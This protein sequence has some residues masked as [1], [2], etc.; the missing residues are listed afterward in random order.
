[1]SD[2]SVSTIRQASLDVRD[3]L[4]IEKI[5]DF[6]RRESGDDKFDVVEAKSPDATGVSSGGLFLT[7]RDGSGETQRLFLKY[8]TQAKV[9]P[10][11][12]YDIAGQYRVQSVLYAAG[13]PVPEPLYLDANGDQLGRAGF[14]MRVVVGEPGSSKAWLEG[15]LA[16]VEPQERDGML[17]DAVRQMV[18]MH[19]I[20][21][22]KPE[23]AFLKEIAPGGNSIER[24]IRWSLDLI[25]YHGFSDPR[26]DAAAAALRL[27]IPDQY[28]DVFNHGDNKFDNYL[29]SDGKVASIIDFEMANFAPPQMDLAYLLFTTRN[30]TP[31]DS[32]NP[33]WF[34][35]EHALISLYEGAGGIKI[36]DFA[37]F[38]DVAAFKF[39][40][41][42]LAFTS[43]LGILAQA[44]QMFTSYWAA[45]ESIPSKYN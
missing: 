39:S 23:L 45:I 34:P 2:D 16:K 20:D 18:R 7:C 5:V 3:A 38:Q 32:P 42:I 40:C 15:A 11:H 31:P 19:S 37:Y 1:M 44:P 17:H 8:D 36:T 43:R 21:T 10:F 30:L 29:F 14:V 12:I 27:A 9:R 28:T 35:D 25:K 41:M 24:E 6:L 4:P 33:G 22:S 13:L 26:I